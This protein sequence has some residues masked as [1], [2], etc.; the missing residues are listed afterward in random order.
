ML[1]RIKSS[2]GVLEKAPHLHVGAFFLAIFGIVKAKLKHLNTRLSG[3]LHC[4]ELFKSLYATDASVYRKIPLAV[5]FP[6]SAA[7]I[8]Q[9]IAFAKAEKITLIPRTAGTSLAGQCV[10][11]GIVVDVSKHFTKIIS[12]D[13]DKKQV[14]VQPG[15]IRDQ[16]NDFLKE[17]GLFFG[18]N[19]STANR[20]MIGGMVGNNSSGTTSIQ[21]GVTRDKV[22]AMKTLLSDGTNVTFEAIDEGRFHEKLLLNDREGDIYRVV[23]D[24]LKSIEVQERILTQ[25]P[26]PEIHRRNTGYAIDALLQ[27]VPFT[28]KGTPFNMCALLAGSEGTLAFTTEITLQLDNLPPAFGVVVAS[29]HHSI[30]QC[31]QA[32]VPAMKHHLY[33]CE[34][35][36]KVILDCTKNNKEQQKNRFFVQGDPQAILMLEVR[37]H[38]LDG[39]RLKA[40]ALIETL[41]KGNHSYAHPMLIGARN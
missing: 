40:K 28:N 21:Y 9:L 2:Q 15:V 8:Q 27:Q 4:D 3:S 19:T 25:F 18:P 32:V 39:A 37:D 17:H 16:L 38:S 10:G 22:V 36:D 33:T 6:K 34:M 41:E 29:H 13:V 12:L 30:A 23:Y 14:T 24:S 11:E 26:K 5:A 31:M 7:D 35:M 20:C 1:K